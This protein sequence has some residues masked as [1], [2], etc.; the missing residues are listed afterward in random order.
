MLV[1]QGEPTM[2]R[3]QGLGISSVLAGRYFNLT[4]LRARASIVPEQLIVTWPGTRASR[5]AAGQ[6]AGPNLLLA[7]GEK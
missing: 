1:T 5:A 3:K 6:N 2:A 7:V 4:R